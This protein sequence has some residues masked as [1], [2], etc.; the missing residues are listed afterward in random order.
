MNSAGC[1]AVGY[2][3]TIDSDKP[4]GLTDLS[5]YVCVSRTT[6]DLTGIQPDQTT[7]P[8]L[9]CYAAA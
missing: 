9:S 8:S 4:T 2:D 1:M 3:T 6:V 5:S 7:N